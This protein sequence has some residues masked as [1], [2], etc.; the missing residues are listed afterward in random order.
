LEALELC[1]CYTTTTTQII[2]LVAA[3]CPQMRHFKYDEGGVY[4]ADNNSDALAI[5]RL[6]ELRSLQLLRC[7]LDNKGLTVILD[8]CSHLEFLDLR[9][10]YNVNI[11][12]SMRDKCAGIKMKKLYPYA[13]ND[14]T[15]YFKPGSPSHIYRMCHNGNDERDCQFLYAEGYFSD[16]G[17]DSEDSDHS[18]CF[19]Q[20]ETDYDE[21]E[22]S[23]DK[24][25]RR[26]R[27]RYL[28]I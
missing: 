21:Y 14:F 4:Y 23:F 24:G 6:H 13:Y 3:T 20:A 16:E 1:E 26:H 27:H 12:S 10:C 17:Y 25:A 5:A 22:R 9:D 18:Y 15:K 11:D 19:S 2:E 7:N 8:N 28:R